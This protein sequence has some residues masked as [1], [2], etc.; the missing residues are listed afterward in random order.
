MCLTLFN[1]RGKRHFAKCISL[2]YFIIYLFNQLR[3]LRTS[4]HL[5][6]RPGQEAKYKYSNTTGKHI[7]TRRI[8]N[9]RSSGKYMILGGVLQA[10]IRIKEK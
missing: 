10:E 8:V 3:A 4:S 5:K 7:D 1:G 2:F 9:Q 6:C